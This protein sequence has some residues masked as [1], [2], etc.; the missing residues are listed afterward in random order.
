MDRAPETN[1][2]VE[3]GRE[4]RVVWI[5]LNWPEQK[6]LLTPATV[7]ALLDALTEAASSRETGAVLLLQKGD[8]FCGGID[9]SSLADP[10]ARDGFSAD[11]SRLFTILSGY[12]LPVVAAVHGACAGGGVGLVAACHLALAATGTKFGITDI[13]FGLWPF[14]FYA[15]LTAA[16]GPRRAR[17]L[18]LTG[19]AFSAADAQA[20]GLVHEVVPAFELE[21]RAFQ[22]A[23][24]LAGL[25]AEAVSA[26]LQFARSAALADAAAAFESALE[27]TDF[28]EGLA[29]HRQRRRPR[30]PSLE[31]SRE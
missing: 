11:L 22:V 2:P 26:G 17:E 21:D 9:Y 5:R 10:A 27:T 6:N 16:V 12:A 23:G 28:A 19:R 15:A 1:H 18:S 7:R 4:G 14:P 3:R 29:A 20:Y 8:V 25:S 30:W 24:I 13:H 31:R